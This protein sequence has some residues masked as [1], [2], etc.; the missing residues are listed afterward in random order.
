MVVGDNLEQ[1]DKQMFP[2]EYEPYEDDIDGGHPRETN[3]LGEITPEDID[4]YVGA[5]VEL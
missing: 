3:Q 1:N 4:E 5:E 2:P